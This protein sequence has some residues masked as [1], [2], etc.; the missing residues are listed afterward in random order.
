ML[1]KLSLLFASLFSSGTS[2]TNEHPQKQTNNP[3]SV[4]TTHP[5]TLHTWTLEVALSS[6]TTNF[7]L[8]TIPS[9]AVI[10]SGF[11]DSVGAKQTKV[12]KNITY[13]AIR[14]SALGATKAAKTS[15]A[16]FGSKVVWRWYLLCYMTSSGYRYR[17]HRTP[18]HKNCTLKVQRRVI[19]LELS[20]L[21]G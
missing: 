20:C 11:L 8:V 3:L 4:T 17:P 21:P 7:T 6:I 16:L 15:H 9:L 14:R 1:A 13:I 2:G 19:K 10:V 5:T 18:V 12:S